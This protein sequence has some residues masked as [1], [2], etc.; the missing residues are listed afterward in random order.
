MVPLTVHVVADDERIGIQQVR[1]CMVEGSFQIHVTK[2]VGEG[3]EANMQAL[4]PQKPLRLIRDWEVG[5][6]EFL[7]LTPTRY[8]VTARMTLH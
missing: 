3:K 2:E 1:I 8:T 5:G 4:R 6:R 7:Y